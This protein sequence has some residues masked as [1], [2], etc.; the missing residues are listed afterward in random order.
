M[1]PQLLSCRLF[2]VP[3]SQGALTTALW[4]FLWLCRTTNK[5][6]GIIELSLVA[7][8]VAPLCLRL[9]VC[10][11]KPRELSASR[12]SLGHFQQPAS[13]SPFADV[14]HGP[15]LSLSLIHI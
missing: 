6:E 14:L 1:N 11:S 5:Q 8:A 3:C 2:G 10:A 15:E 7:G 12:L 13:L 4:R 9:M